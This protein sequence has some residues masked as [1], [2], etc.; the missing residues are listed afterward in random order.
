MK[1]AIAIFLF[2]LANVYAQ[3]KDPL[4]AAKIISDRVIKE[5][6]FELAETEQKPAIDLQVIDF[7]K[8]GINGNDNTVY[9]LAKIEINENK[10]LR[11]GISY[12]APVNVWLNDKLVFQSKEK[13]NFQFG[14][15]A[16][17]IFRFQDTITFNLAKGINRVVIGSV[18]ADKAVVYIREITGAEEPAISK[19]LPLNVS[20][21]KITWSWGYIAVPGIK[22]KNNSVIKY[23]D[24]EILDKL[25]NGE[26]TGEGKI[27][28]SA[29]AIVKKL[30]IDPKST[31]KKDSYADWNYPNGALMMSIM[32]LYEESKEQRFNEFIKKYCDFTYDNLAQFKKQYFNNHDLRGS[33]YR[34]FRKCM[35]DDAG[36]PTLPFI[37]YALVNKSNKYDS[38]IDDMT[39]YVMKVQ[40]RL[41]GGT[42]CR[43][44]P[45]EWTIWADDLFMSVPLLVKYGA[46]RNNAQY[47]DE[48]AKQIINFNKY[49]FDEHKKIYKHGWFSW[50]NS[51]SNVFWG[52]ANGW[53]VWATIEA[54][55][56]IPQSH[57]DYERI[58]EI[59]K[60]HLEGILACQD[61][62]GMWHQILDDKSS[63]EESS[64]TAMFIIGLSNAIRNGIL[65]IKYSEN[66]LKA[67]NALQK[68]ISSDGIV[69]DIC[70]GT[71]IGD[72]PEFYKT[73]DRY[74]ND[75]RGLG[76]VIVSA[77][78]VF[79][80]QNFM[81]R[82]N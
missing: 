37:E 41:P 14:E 64:C 16:Y 21:N 42:L 79:K 52:R 81:N 20:A 10:L 78:E 8:S 9:A 48:A 25:F 61:K 26:I 70:C 13:V 62:S 75:P 71:G 44:E 33:Y 80:L 22:T 30:I 31:F 28:I 66:V 59:L 39:A 3:Y 46:L 15:I 68:N 57:P 23:P 58:R 51:R 63:F 49:L 40:S 73:R 38:I 1:K 18:N 82:V 5:T 56:Y 55:N 60:K 43:P 76:A 45:K 4:T 34:F 24:K 65:D 29:A 35:L 50:T 7:A 2:L 53:I 32:K 6:L 17:S 67:W 47:L 27:N 11:F 77:V 12:S 74:N 36:A 72:T 69:K 54:L 19:F